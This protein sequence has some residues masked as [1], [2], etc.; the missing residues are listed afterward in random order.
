L[1][2]FGYPTRKPPCPA[3]FMTSR[4]RSTLP[5]VFGTPV[6]AVVRRSIRI[7][8]IRIRPIFA[9]VTPPI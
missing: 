8:P 4:Y 2:R 5:V 9:V 7:R 1:A 6:A 3:S